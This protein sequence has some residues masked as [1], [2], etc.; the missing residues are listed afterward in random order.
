MWPPYTF[1][2]EGVPTKGIAWELMNAVYARLGIEIDMCLLPQERML[3]YLRDG[4]KDVVS[5]ISKN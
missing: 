5:V 1:E 4:K 2:T 3:Q